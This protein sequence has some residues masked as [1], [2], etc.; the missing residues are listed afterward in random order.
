MKE[1]NVLQINTVD[2]GGGAEQVAV[3]LNNL[4]PNSVLL[5]NYRFS[6]LPSVIEFPKSFFDKL[7]NILSV[8]GRKTKLIKQDVKRDFFMGENFNFTY[9]KLKKIKEYQA[10]Q[11]IHLHNIHGGYFDLNDL[12]KIAKE[13]IIVWTLHDMWAITG[14]ESYIMDDEN[15]KIGIGV[16]PYV[17]LPPLN[18]PYIDRRNHF[19]QKKHEILNSINDRIHFVCPSFW[20][21]N[22]LKE[23]YVAK[24]MKHVSVIHNGVNTQYFFNKKERGWSKP[25]VLI[26]NFL[27]N[28][29]LKGTYLFWSI[30][31]EIKDLCDLA[32]VGDK[33][34]DDVTCFSHYNKI[35]GRKDL[36]DL[37]NSVDILVFPSM[38][39]NFPLTTLE[40][41]IA[42]VFLIS[43]DTGGIIEQ[44]QTEYGALFVRG[45]S[46][47]LLEKI[48]EALLNF[49]ETRKKGEKAST[50][51]DKNFNLNGAVKKYQELYEKIIGRE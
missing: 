47:D 50:E 1:I 21:E 10:A 3:D 44:I 14:G 36:N 25:R 28:S 23:S 49:S 40:A 15:F 33:P 42:G 8:I 2:F 17:D 13:K 38:A 43:S 34:G 27:K 9:S 39:D 5:V 24:N 41:M 32:V 26:F 7:L 16:T 19:I 11:I 6:N 29:Q 18:N 37:Y 4:L 30:Y 12:R 31:P 46:E 22:S 20:L 48:Q 45:N 35:S 51:I